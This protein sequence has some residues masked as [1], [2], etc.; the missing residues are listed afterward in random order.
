MAHFNFVISQN[1]KWGHASFYIRHRM[2]SS[3]YAYR[4]VLFYKK[5]TAYLTVIFLNKMPIHC[6]LTGL[7]VFCCHLQQTTCLYEI[8]FSAVT[9]MKS[10]KRQLGK[11]EHC[12]IVSHTTMFEQESTLQCEKNRLVS[13][14]R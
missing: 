3:E 10:N 8:A 14:L 4:K 11:T 12:Q 9:A 7:S 6:S 1:A 13:Y 5:S 2:T